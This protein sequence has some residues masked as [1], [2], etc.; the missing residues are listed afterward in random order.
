MK[1]HLCLYVAFT[2]ISGGISAYNAGAN[3]VQS[4]DRMDIGTTHHDYA[5]D[6]VARAKFYKRNGYWDIWVMIRFESPIAYFASN[7]KNPGFLPQKQLEWEQAMK[8]ETS[9]SFQWFIFSAKAKKKK[10][11]TLKDNTTNNPNCN[12]FFAIYFLSHFM[13]IS[14]WSFHLCLQFLK[15]HINAARKLYTA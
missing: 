5:N 13:R 6:V 10:F 2:F 7:F 12:L 14:R 4:Y 15:Q 1:F 8:P 9:A 11:P 3:N